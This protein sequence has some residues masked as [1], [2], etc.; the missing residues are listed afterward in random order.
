MS[1]RYSITFED[2]PEVPAESVA[3]AA[4][5]QLRREGGRRGRQVELGRRRVRHRFKPVPNRFEPGEGMFPRH[6]WDTGLLRDILVALS[7]LLH[8]TRHTWNRK[9][10][11]FV[12]LLLKVEWNFHNTLLEHLPTLWGEPSLMYNPDESTLKFC[13]CVEMCLVVECTDN[14]LTSY[15]WAEEGFH[16]ISHN[17]N[18]FSQ[19]SCSLFVH[20]TSISHF[21]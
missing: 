13:E 6:G 2:V 4:E 18:V 20:L 19:A 3:A 21:L 12:I 8:E 16:V 17:L 7:S 5:P 9:E 11:L 14:H 10:I 15:Q 1:Y